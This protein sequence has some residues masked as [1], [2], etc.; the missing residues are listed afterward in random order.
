VALP[1]H[2]VSL[3]AV[4][5]GKSNGKLPADV[6]VSVPGQA[7]GPT[8]TLVAPAARAWRA[9]CVAA[10]RA[11][12]T[13]KA[14]SAADSYR[15]YATQEALFRSR[16]STTF[17]SGRPAVTWQGQTWWLRG[18]QAQAAVP[19]TS[20]HGLGLAVDIGEELDGDAA[21][22]SITQATVDWL[23]V[24]AGHYGWSA[25]L[26]SEPWHWR[27]Y[28]GDTLP[29]AVL[30]AEQ[31]GDIDMP[32]YFK[33]VP[34]GRVCIT[35]GT[36]WHWITDPKALDSSAYVGKFNGATYPDPPPEIPDDELDQGRVFGPQSSAATVSNNAPSPEQMAALTTALQGA[37]TAAVMSD[38]TLVDRIAE[39]VAAQLAA[40]LQA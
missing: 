40:R 31:Q 34:S 7:G 23:A 3:P 17:I 14:T 39:T 32:W 33:A 24:N 21:T 1:I 16:Y 4:L 30:A 6:L 18:G 5:S 25:E 9:L 37:V 19:G 22:E 35:N 8:V 12:H 28:S 38:A 13:L 26:Q 20:N 2:A 11:G 36:S 27:Y 15:T 29:P 10:M